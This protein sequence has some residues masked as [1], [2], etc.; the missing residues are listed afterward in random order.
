MCRI[1]ALAEY[2]LASQTPLGFSGSDVMDRL[3][4][5][6]VWLR[7]AGSDP[8]RAALA[9]SAGPDVGLVQQPT[10]GSGG[11]CRAVLR[12]SVTVALTSAEP[13]IYGTWV[14]ELSALSS[15][16]LAGTGLADPNALGLELAIRSGT[17][18]ARRLTYE[19]EPGQPLRGWLLTGGDTPEVVMRLSESP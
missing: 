13:G 18:P 3:S 11:E 15:D 5:R 19:L 17:P 9:F 8:V 14:T 16:D 10:P 7:W 6:D 2:D 4:A 1:G 12:L